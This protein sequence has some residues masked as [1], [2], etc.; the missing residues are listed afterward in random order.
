MEKIKLLVLL[1]FISTNMIAQEVKIPHDL[2][3]ENAEDYKKTESLVL[4]SV[5]WLLNTPVLENIEKRHGEAHQ[6]KKGR[7]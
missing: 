7:N 2:V 5:D 1:L 6:A 4:K 3:F